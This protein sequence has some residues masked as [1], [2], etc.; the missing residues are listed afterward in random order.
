M[1]APSILINVVDGSS[2]LCVVH[3]CDKLITTVAVLVLA[4]SHNAYFAVFMMFI[5][6]ILLLNVIRRSH[7]YCILVHE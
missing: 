1:T 7:P 2:L 3:C 6:I 4:I 5:L